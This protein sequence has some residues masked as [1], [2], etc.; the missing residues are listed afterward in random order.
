MECIFVPRHKFLHSPENNVIPYPSSILFQNNL[1]L[2][3]FSLLKP[4]KKN[5]KNLFLKAPKNTLYKLIYINIIQRQAEKLKS[6]PP[7]SLFFSSPSIASTFFLTAK[8]KRN[9]N[10]KIFSRAFF[11]ARVSMGRSKKSVSLR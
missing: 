9:K 11:L 3:V 1:F 8:K 4:E 2:F 10:P 6:H 5:K 7:L